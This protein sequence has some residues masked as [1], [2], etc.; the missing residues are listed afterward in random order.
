MTAEFLDVGLA[1]GPDH[2]AVEK[3]AEHS[4]RCRRRFRRGRPTFALV[5]VERKAA[6]LVDADFKEETRV[7]VEDLAKIIPMLLPWLV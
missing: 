5:E 2:D 1:E 6:E 4:R 3:A 7:R